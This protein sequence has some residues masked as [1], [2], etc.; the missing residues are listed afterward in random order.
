V[1]NECLSVA[2]KREAQI[3]QYRLLGFKRVT[4]EKARGEGEICENRKTLHEQLIF[5]LCVFRK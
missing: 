3:S 2:K 5:R 4:V 1:C